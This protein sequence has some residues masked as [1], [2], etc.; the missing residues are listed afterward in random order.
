MNRNV[1]SKELAD[2]IFNR[3]HDKG[4]NFYKS[5]R[6][7]EKGNP[8]VTVSKGLVDKLEQD[9]RY[10][11]LPAATN[12]TS[13]EEVMNA[14]D[15]LSKK[16]NRELPTITVLAQKLPLSGLTLGQNAVKLHTP[17]GDHVSYSALLDSLDSIIQTK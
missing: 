4:W 8:V 12:P 5:E 11:L 7:T 17:S 15:D 14:L 16:L 13:Y 3:F 1:Y 6:L 9:V 10:V 2:D